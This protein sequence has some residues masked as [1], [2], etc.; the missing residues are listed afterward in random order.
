MRSCS[1][2]R[3]T[4][5]SYSSFLAYF[6]VYNSIIKYSRRN[7]VRRRKRGR[8]EREGGEEEEGGGGGKGNETFQRSM[9]P[10]KSDR[11]CTADNLHPMYDD[12]TDDRIIGEFF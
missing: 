6:D 12:R 3:S 4:F 9:I 1:S 11:S 10:H 5:H 2:Y 8:G 7:Q